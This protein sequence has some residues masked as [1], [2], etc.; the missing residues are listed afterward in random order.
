MRIA[1]L[2]WKD[3][4]RGDG[5]LRKIARQIELWTEAGH[6]VRLFVLGPAT[7]I[8]DGARE[9]PHALYPYAGLVSRFTRAWRLARELLGW[10][11]DLV[12]FRLG[13]YY[14]GLG[15]ALARV[16]T[17]LD[18]NSDDLAESRKALAPPQFLYYRLTRGIVLRR[19]RG[20][21]AVTHEL[22]ARYAAYGKPTRV[23]SNG[24]ELDAVTPLP[25]P[26]NDAPRLFFVG[27]TYQ[28]RT[29][30]WHGVDHIL[31]LARR[32][33]GWRFD[34]VGPTPEALPAP[35]PANVD[36]HGFL[37]PPEYARLLAR[38]DVAIGSLALYRNGMEEA[39][40]L[41]VREYLA[42]GVPT[43]I[44]Y[45]DTDFPDPPPFLLPIPNAADGVARAASEIERFVER[46]RGTR[47]DRDAIAHLD[48]RRKE[49]ER[50][51]F[52]DQI[53]SDHSGPPL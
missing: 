34:L 40:V 18:L 31:E 17:V 25:A 33:P 46:A 10:R 53:R 44:G 49:A 15:R 29:V 39:C 4:R 21:C 23:I 14:P 35:P 30:P 52:L 27:S 50:L 1:F 36:A 19:A 28:G 48:L 3:V 5:A 16:P 42:S 47:V 8:W 32:F 51:E 2:T 43:I 22:A 37:P 24:I 6:A 41:K 38:A 9:L 45:R 11:P 7:E 20:L 12:F 26:E 13:T